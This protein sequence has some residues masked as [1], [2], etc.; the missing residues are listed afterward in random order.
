MGLLLTGAILLIA[1][2]GLFYLKD[3]FRI[4][5]LARLAYSEPVMRIAVLA[6]VFMVVGVLLLARRWFDAIFSTT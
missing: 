2:L 1:V 6:V 5:W 3:E 4:A